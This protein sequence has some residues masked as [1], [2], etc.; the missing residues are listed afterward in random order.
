MPNEWGKNRSTWNWEEEGIEVIDA[1]DVFFEKFT[2]W[3]EQA[4]YGKVSVASYDIYPEIITYNTSKIGIMRALNAVQKINEQNP[5]TCPIYSGD[6]AFTTYD[7][8]IVTRF[9]ISGVSGGYVL[10]FGADS[11]TGSDGG[12]TAAHEIGHSLSGEKPGTS[13][14]HSSGIDII[15]GIPYRY[16]GLYDIMANGPD[17]DFRLGM[18]S[19]NWRN[20]VGW[21][22][23]S[24]ILN[25]SEPGQFEIFAHDSPYSQGKP[26]ALRF[27]L[28]DDSVSPVTRRYY[29]IEFRSSLIPEP[30]GTW[31]DGSPYRLS[32]K[33]QLFND[34]LEDAV[35]VNYRDHSAKMWLVDTTPLSRIKSF[36][37]YADRLDSPLKIGNVFYLHEL[38]LVVQPVAHGTDPEIDSIII[39]VA[40]MGTNTCGDGNFQTGEQ[41]DGGE[42]CK[43]DCRCASGYEPTQ[44][45]S[46][47]C[48]IPRNDHKYNFPTQKPTTCGNGVYDFPEQCDGGMGCKSDC[49][50]E[51]HFLVNYWRASTSCVH[52]G[53][54]PDYVFTPAPPA[55]DFEYQC[56][57]LSCRFTDESKDTANV[58]ISWEWLY[59]FNYISRRLGSYEQN[60]KT[61]VNYPK[62]GI[63]KVTLKIKNHMGFS[64]TVVKKITVTENKDPISST[65][66]TSTSTVPP[67]SSSS[68]SSTST[69]TVPL[70][71]GAPIILSVISRI[72]YKKQKT[73]YKLVWKGTDAREVEIFRDG[74]TIKTT[75]NRGKFEESIRFTEIQP[76]SYQVCEKSSYI[77]SEVAKTDP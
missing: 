74:K 55:A 11:F 6:G 13:I 1:I 36:T 40:R 72:N 49:T 58:I 53:S 31:S 21:V 57:G 66:S 33:N 20:Q 24:Q 37:G 46:P 44:P 34:S 73:K 12:A 5:G 39:N 8:C 17:V 60:G 10:E 42:N 54:S 67:S 75:K 27:Y 65:S 70:P 76:R 29:H 52:A 26:L 59:D 18:Y 2:P 45:W 28:D 71:T 30:V 48:Q 64:D 38:G 61:V 63:Y 47:G 43:S 7:F 41:C 50:C 4:S 35:I 22:E 68:T 25:A 51:D 14:G 56:D 62:A 3:I 77:C 9:G 32:S 19:S 16:A 15:A 69:S 23:D